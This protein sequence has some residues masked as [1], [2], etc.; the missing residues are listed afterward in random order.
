MGHDQAHPEM[1]ATAFA[2]SSTYCRTIGVHWLHDHKPGSD[3]QAVGQ[4]RV[5]RDR[6]GLPKILKASSAAGHTSA[7][8]ERPLQ[9]VSKWIRLHL[10]LL[11]KLFNRPFAD[12]FRSRYQR[13]GHN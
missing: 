5:R 4:G 9:S 13:P 7:P 1:K 2:S 8:F 11:F 6:M 12:T 3:H 10:K